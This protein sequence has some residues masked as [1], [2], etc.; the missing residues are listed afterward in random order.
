MSTSPFEKENIAT[1]LPRRKQFSPNNL[2]AYNIVEPLARGGA[3]PHGEP[4]IHS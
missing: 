2:F 3:D 4:S 1:R